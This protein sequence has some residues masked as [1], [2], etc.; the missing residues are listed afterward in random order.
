MRRR[1]AEPD[2]LVRKWFKLLKLPGVKTAV[3]ECQACL[4]WRKAQN[5]CRQRAH[6]LTECTKYQELIKSEDRSMK[7]TVQATLN[8][9]AEPVDEVKKARLNCKFALA[10]YTTSKAF[11]SFDDPTW[12]DF[13]KE[14][15]Y[16]TLTRQALAGPLLDSVY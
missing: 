14:L 8:R 10:L 11:S 15:G 12:T 3:A 5:N 6:L 2:E 16:T 9:Y 1:G 7:F 4:K 13:F